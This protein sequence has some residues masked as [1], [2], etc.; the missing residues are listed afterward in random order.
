MEP[1]SQPLFD[2]REISAILKRAAEIQG[3]D[4]PAR[5]F[6]LSLVELQQLA[7]EAGID[8][9]SVAAAVA[10]LDRGGEGDHVNIWGGPLSLTLDRV[11]EGEVNEATWE[12]MVAA[13]RRSFNDTGEVQPWGQALEWTHSGR[14]SGVQAHVTVTPR[15]GRTRIQVFWHEPV[16]A[17]PV[18]VIAGVFALIMIPVV[19]EALALVSLTGAFL[20]LAIVSTLFL[21]ARW[22]LSRMA[23]KEKRNVRHLM[24]KLE[25]IAAEQVSGRDAVSTEA[26]S[27]EI[28]LVTPPLR[29]DDVDAGPE[30]DD[31][32]QPPRTRISP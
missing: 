22:T 12:A 5:A 14:A 29:L 21:L 20:Y 32:R 6:G 9:R 15:D 24:A 7:A 23:A 1:D 18:Y 30:H 3:A 4:G 19:F 13:V 27:P 8:P 25:R 28:D 31:A 2:E 17:A 26:R 10:E 16:M 11:V